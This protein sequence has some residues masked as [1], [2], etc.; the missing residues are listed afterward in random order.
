[1]E[2]LEIDDDA[3]M[4]FSLTKANITDFGL[5][6]FFEVLKD[7]VISK[8]FIET[9]YRV[10]IKIART[11]LKPLHQV[12]EMPQPDAE[13]NEPSEEAKVHAQRQID[14]VAKLNAEIEKHN[15]EVSKIQSKVKIAFRPMQDVLNRGECALMR[16]NN[17]RDAKL[18]ETALDQNASVEAFVNTSQQHHAP[19]HQKQGSVNTSGKQAPSLSSQRDQLSMEQDVSALDNFQLEDVPAKMI[20]LNPHNDERDVNLIVYHSEAQYAL[21]KL[22]IEV[23]KRHFKELEKLN[24]N[25]VLAH[26]AQKSKQLDE[27]FEDYII[28]TLKY[29]RGCQY[30][31]RNLKIT[32]KTFLQS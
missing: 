31:D 18:D 10:V 13:G 14:E 19:S 32:W 1:M 23:A 22:V 17:F 5:A 16:V 26:T 7:L 8:E 6:F 30:T 15:E 9:L 2:R 21:R 25:A 27:R 29:G 4:R 24:L 20:L 12:P 3:F 11:K 28:R